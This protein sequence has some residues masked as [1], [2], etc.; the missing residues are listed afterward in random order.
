MTNSLLLRCRVLSQG[1]AI[2]CILI[3][4][5]ALLA[6][7]FD[8]EM[9]GRAIPAWSLMQP[10]S[11]LCFILTGMALWLRVVE[12]SKKW[13]SH[14]AQGGLELRPYWACSPSAS[15]SSPGS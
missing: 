11:A 3:G 10:N 5:L 9:L 13:Q 7:I 4:A 6:W 12:S 8:L 2:S 15:T 1:A 14:L